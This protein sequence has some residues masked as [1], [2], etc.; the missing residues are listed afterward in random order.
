MLTIQYSQNVSEY[1]GTAYDG[2]IAGKVCGGIE[3]N[4][5][6]LTGLNLRPL[7]DYKPKMTIDYSALANSAKQTEELY[8]S[9]EEAREEHFLQ[10]KQK[11]E[12]LKQIAANSEHTVNS[13]KETN[14]LLRENNE[15]LK[16]ENAQLTG[17][18]NEIKQVLKC[19]F[20]VEK[21][22]GDDHTELL[23]Q[24]TALA[25]QID[26]SINETGK[27]NWK[28]LIANNTSNALLM[29]IQVFL[30]NKGLL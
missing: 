13:L 14:D 23:R 16:K 17:A 19:L 12:A 6:D 25:V 30:H 22:N 3:M 2:I 18:L 10:E 15:L 7:D 29:G 21:E 20:D 11:R 5:T 8:A 24:A 28:E 26:M 1:I 9:I 4:F 27:L